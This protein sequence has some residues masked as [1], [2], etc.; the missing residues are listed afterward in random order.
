MET[1]KMWDALG[2]PIIEIL[3]RQSRV[4]QDDPFDPV[5]TE[6]TLNRSYLKQYTPSWGHN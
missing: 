6:T 2:L 4:D 5:K 3:S 1:E